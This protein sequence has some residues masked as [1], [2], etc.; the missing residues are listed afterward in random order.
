[1]KTM[2]S[3]SSNSQEGIGVRNNKRKKK[4][5]ANSES[6]EDA[7][8]IATHVETP[9]VHV[10]QRYTDLQFPSTIVTPRHVMN[11]A[12]IAT[13]GFSSTSLETA[14]SKLDATAT[15]SYTDNVSNAK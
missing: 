9:I 6:S 13:S 11:T 5:R 14:G 3:G 8:R 10:S 1:M 12:T 2:F 7:G 4:L 15:D